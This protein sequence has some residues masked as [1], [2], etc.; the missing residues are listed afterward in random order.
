VSYHINEA[1]LKYEEILNFYKST[2]PNYGWDEVDRFMGGE[3]RVH[4][5]KKYTYD[6]YA[7]SISLSEDDFNTDGYKI[8]VR[9][10]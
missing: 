5:P 9:Y 4:V 10:W 2:L 8:I 3:W 6:S 7:Y 1:N